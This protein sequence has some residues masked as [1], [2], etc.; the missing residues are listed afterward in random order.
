MTT[1]YS[2]ELPRGKDGNTKTAYPP[3]KQAVKSWGAVP[4]VSSVISLTD[5]TTEME[6]AAQGG[7]GI[8]IKWV[9]QNDTVA[10]VIASGATAN[11]DHIIP[12]GSV[13]RFVVPV[14]P[15]DTPAYTSV[16]GANVQLGLINRVAWIQAGAAATASCSVF[17][18]EYR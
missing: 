11:F 17:G 1:N 3:A 10:S 8:A 9:S 2:A 6:I 14:D 4:T 13:R 16:V 5:D 12:T 7:A 15:N 18:A